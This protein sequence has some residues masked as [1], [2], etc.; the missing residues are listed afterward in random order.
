M[1]PQLIGLYSPAPQSGK[2]TIAKVLQSHGYT[3]VP[4]AEPLKLML[5]PLLSSLGYT[6]LEVHRFLY[7]QKGECVPELGITPRAML[8]T[9]G[10]EWGR[11]CISPDV[12]LK[13]WKV[14]VS[15]H[16]R[17]VVDDVRFVN[18]AELIRSMG[19]QV[20]LIHRP[21]VRRGTNHA[22]EGGLDEWPY[23]SDC[24]Y[25]GSTLEHLEQV[26][27]ARFCW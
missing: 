18:E 27:S 22:S 10:T 19:G 4:F 26:I 25:N 20:W 12:W 15:K 13:H 16:E 7:E 17:V 8:Q 2:T 3:L 14:R 23:F 1:S 24:I 21:G 9:L 5:A 6:D 11:T